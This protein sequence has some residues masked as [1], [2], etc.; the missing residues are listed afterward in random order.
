VPDLPDDL[1]GLILERLAKR[2]EDRVASAALL[3]ERIARCIR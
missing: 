2:P 3:G 1:A